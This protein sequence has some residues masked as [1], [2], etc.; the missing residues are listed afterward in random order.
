M[1]IAF[2][3]FCLLQLADGYTT[4]RALDL[5]GEERMPM[6][7]WAL[8][9][10]HADYAVAAVKVAYIVI[11]FVAIAMMAAPVWSI[12]VA[13]LIAAYMVVNNVAVIRKLKSVAHDR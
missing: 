2:S 7:R 4:V 8:R 11:A 13:D 5:G 9:W 1:L 3:L 12:V 6:I 10:M